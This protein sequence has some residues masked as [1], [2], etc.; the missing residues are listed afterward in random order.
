[1]TPRSSPDLPAQCSKAAPGRPWLLQPPPCARILTSYWP[2]WRWTA[3]RWP[4][5]RRSCKRTRT[6]C[7]RQRRP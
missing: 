1:T 6:L 5:P 4:T 7:W 3:A 2:P